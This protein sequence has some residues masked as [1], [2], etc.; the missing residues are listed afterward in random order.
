VSSRKNRPRAL[1][2]VAGLALGAVSVSSCGGGGPQAASE[3]ETA[4]A[5]S[6]PLATSVAGGGGTW[7]TVPMG[8]LAQ[9]VNT[10]WQLF[11]RRSGALSWSNQVRATATATNGGLVLAPAGGSLLVGVRPSQMLTFTPLIG[12]R[13]GGRS[14]S[15]GLISE[16]L[17]SRPS[18]LALGTD[19]AALAVVNTPDGTEVLDSASNLSSWQVLV[20]SAALASTPSGRACGPGPLSAVGYLPVRLESGRAA[21]AGAGAVVGAS[22]GRPGVAGIFEQA[23]GGWET[24][25]PKLSSAAGQAHV[26]GLF[27]TGDELA[28]LLEVTGSSGPKLI[29]AW[30]KA[31]NT[32]SSSPPFEVTSGERLLSDGAAPGGGLFVLL[33][34][35]GL[36]D[37]I[38][39][40]E[41]GTAGWHELAAP[42]AGTTTVAFGPG[43]TVEALAAG[44]TV[45]T[46]WR[47]ENG[48]GTWAKNQVL[49]VAIQYGSSS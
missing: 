26:L 41:P 14:W 28:A 31:L 23:A 8:N 40:A 37:E 46:V 45:L 33:A 3:V 4:V 49:H 47:L 7:A 29:A 10:F 17:A 9:P 2:V 15:T 48:S 20:T 18:A 39:L 44:R 35:P 25:G 43:R 30:S 1:K 16:G 24:A 38:A 34:R 11:F 27:P 32:W 22:C 6:T 5:L 36:G 13:D 21:G 12:T 19:G 42:P